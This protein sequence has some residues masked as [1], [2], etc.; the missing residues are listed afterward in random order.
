MLLA[1]PLQESPLSLPL[2]SH[3][4]ESL[5]RRHLA[6]IASCAAATLLAAATPAAFALNIVFRDISAQ[7]AGQAM[8]S[9]QLAAF[10]SAADFW[11]SRLADPVT[12]FVDIGFGDQGYNGVLGSTSAA[13]MTSAYST[14]R[15][16][17]AADQTSAQD[18]VALA[19]LDPGAAVAWQVS[20]LDGGSRFDN[21]TFVGCDAQGQC[22]TN[23]R[24]LQ[25]TTAN[26]RALG[27][28]TDTSA[29]NPDGSI[30]FNGAYAALFQFGR[31]GGVAADKVDFVTVAE[32]EL[33]HLLGF[34]SGVDLVDMQYGCAGSADANCMESLATYTPLDLFRY[35]APGLRDVSVGSAAYL[36]VDGGAT[37][38]AGFSS[39]RFGGDGYQADHFAAAQATLM[40]PFIRRGESYDAT[41]TD[42]AAFDA[43]GWDLAQAVPEPGPTALLLIGLSGLMLRLAQSRHR[44]RR[45]PAIGN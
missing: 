31:S 19:H 38:R 16:R 2:P 3:S 24:E 8:G 26:A 21:D 29:V 33:G 40:R 5:L 22:G 13:T 1:G 36:S 6:L 35:S 11:Q 7:T 17:L 42:L 27:M 30:V 18:A 23:N 9:D 25:L 39:G 32:H 37:A 10:R 15:S 4:R 41:A 44:V 14:L 28:V 43:I 45:S 12:V 20:T 34:Q